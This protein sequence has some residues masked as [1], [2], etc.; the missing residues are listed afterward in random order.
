MD[1]NGYLSLLSGDL[2]SAGSDG[3]PEPGPG[4]ASPRIVEIDVPDRGRMR[5]TYEAMQHRHYRS[6]H[7]SWRAVWADQCSGAGSMPNSS[8]QPASTAMP[9]A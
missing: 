4:V 6:S 2:V 5:I 1:H 9:R 3:L 7:W 8:H